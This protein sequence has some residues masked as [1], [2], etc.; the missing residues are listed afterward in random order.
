MYLGAHVISF[1][2]TE[3]DIK[4]RLGKAKAAYSKLE[5]VWK[6]TRFTIKN[7]IRIFKC[8]AISVLLY[9]CVTWRMTQTDQ[10]KLNA[11][12]HKSFR[13]ILK[14]YWPMRITSEEIRRRTGMETIS[15]QVARRRWAWLGHVFRMDHN[16]HPRTALAWVPEGK[17]KREGSTARHMAQKCG[18]GA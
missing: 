10:K 1:G 14:I 8:N 16:S 6:N 9:G 5:K 18:K 4:A 7:K 11:F 2:G 12:L 17:R 13:R 15:S 3:D